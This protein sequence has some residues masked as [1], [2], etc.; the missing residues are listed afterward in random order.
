MLSEYRNKPHQNQ[1][2][3]NVYLSYAYSIPYKK[4]YRIL[5]K[6]YSMCVIISL[7][8]SII[9]LLIYFRFNVF[10]MQNKTRKKQTKN[11]KPTKINNVFTYITQ[12]IYTYY[13]YTI[14]YIHIY[15]VYLCQRELLNAHWRCKN[16][17]HLFKMLYLYT[18]LCEL[19]TNNTYEIYTYLLPVCS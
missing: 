1:S 17:T 5:T 12:E 19:P 18:Q 6:T 11:K 16:S 15:F 14:L 2:F 7:M 13:I 8:L 4:P 3:Q 9:N 10:R